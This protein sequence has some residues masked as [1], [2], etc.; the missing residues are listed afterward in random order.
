MDSSPSGLRPCAA[1]EALETVGRRA[2]ARLVFARGGGATVLT[3]QHVPYPFHVT[4]VFRLHPEAPD[5]ASLYLQ[6][7]SGGLY[8]SDHLTLSIEARPG[9]R[10]FVTT[11]AGT[12][13]HRGGPLPTRQDTR[14][15]VGS[16]AFLAYTP[17]PLILFPG[18]NLSIATEMEV[19]PGARAILT[20]SVACHDPAG[21]GLPFERLTMSL[22]IADPSG[23]VLVRERSA[24][25]GPAFTDA[26]APLGAHR[27]YGT[28]IL[29]GPAELLPAPRT[30]QSEADAAGCLAGA[31]PLPNG[32]GLGLRLLAPDGGRL[33]AGLD[34]LARLAFQA[35]GG[36]APARRRK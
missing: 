27:A 26:N 1:G 34:A 5:L 20:E 10:A 19:A 8:R 32:A 28:M 14:V 11:Q 25:D 30:F 22:R 23:R 3:R 24:I 13:V 33:S 16:D 18:A 15:R 36:C 12:V 21:S 35:L 9:A 29:I 4:R 17:D 31:S 6:S 7:A 2:E